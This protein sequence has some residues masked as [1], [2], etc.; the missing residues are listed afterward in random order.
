MQTHS[1]HQ[2]ELAKAIRM[3]LESLMVE[4]HNAGLQD[5][6]TALASASLVA[7]DSATVQTAPRVRR[8][9]QKHR[10]GASVV[11][12]TVSAAGPRLRLVWSRP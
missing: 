6:A 8:S 4:A 12:S 7:E 11:P 2:I 10:V 3:C 1:D 9:G 5:L